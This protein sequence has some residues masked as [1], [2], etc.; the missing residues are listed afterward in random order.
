M[1]LYF[2]ISILLLSSFLFAQTKTQIEDFEFM[3]DARGA[4]D[5]KITVIQDYK[6]TKAIEKHIKV[7]NNKFPGWRVQLYFGAGSNSLAQAKGLKTKFRMKYG[8]EYGTYIIYDAPYF[9]LRVGD[10]RTRAEAM[11]FSKKIAKEYKSRWVMRDQIFYPDR[12]DKHKDPDENEDDDDKK[13]N[14]K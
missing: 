13:K 8:N 14:E 3:P 10:F 9:K 6:V 7:N 4:N 1:K 5:G 11:Y 2:T 12:D